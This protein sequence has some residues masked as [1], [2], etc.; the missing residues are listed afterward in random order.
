MGGSMAR[1]QDT[2]LLGRWRIVEIEG[3]PADYADLCGPAHIQFD[4][5]RAHMAF[6][7][8]QIA[9]DCWYGATDAHFTFAGDDEMTEV[10]GDGDAE[11]QP[12]G[13]LVCEVQFHMGDE[14]LIRA[15]R[16]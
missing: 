1:G 2:A 7:V 11:L 14:M 13:T 16:W 9:L 8:V 5:D 4:S 3:Y 15:R 6:G 10:S 12:D